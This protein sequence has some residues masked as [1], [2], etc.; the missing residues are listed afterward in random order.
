[1]DLYSDAYFISGDK[2]I[3]L[4]AATRVRLI[5]YCRTSSFYEMEADWR[6]RKDVANN[7]FVFNVRRCFSDAPGT[8]NEHFPLAHLTAMHRRLHETEAVWAC[9]KRDRPVPLTLIWLNRDEGGTRNDV[10]SVYK[11]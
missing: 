8:V 10:R 9:F 4:F 1:M 7:I 6:Q 5:G 11:I 3:L 2:V